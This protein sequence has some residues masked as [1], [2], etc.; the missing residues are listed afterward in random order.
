MPE[1]NGLMRIFWPLD[2]PRI[3]TPGVIVGWRNSELDVLVV[4]ILEDVEVR[5]PM[6]LI[7]VS[8]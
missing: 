2:I 6:L 5:S 7:L 4:A 8:G 3:N 1:H